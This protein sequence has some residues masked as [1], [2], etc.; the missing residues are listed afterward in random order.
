M[1]RKSSAET[2]PKR[3][4]VEGLEEYFIPWL[5]E[6]TPGSPPWED[7]SRRTTLV[8]IV[9]RGGNTSLFDSTTLTRPR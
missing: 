4:L 1:S 3:L 9:P 6:Q 2:H 5:V 8:G 7:A